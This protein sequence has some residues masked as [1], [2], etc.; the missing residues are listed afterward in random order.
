MNNG[1]RALV[2][3]WQL[4]I[5]STKRATSIETV[6]VYSNARNDQDNKYNSKDCNNDVE[7]ERP[8]LDADLRNKRQRA[9]IQDMTEGPSTNTHKWGG[10]DA[11]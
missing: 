10:G 8:P 3:K 1:A 9:H 7:V 11:K 4:T 6:E 5:D 2:L